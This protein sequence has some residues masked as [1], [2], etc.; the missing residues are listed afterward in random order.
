[1][2]IHGNTMKHKKPRT[3]KEKRRSMEF[4]QLLHLMADMYQEA[5]QENGHLKS[6]L[7]AHSLE[8]VASLK[9]D[10]EAMPTSSFSD[11]TGKSGK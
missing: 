7:A 3:T 8:V 11:P 10:P 9:G 6:A 4:D 2:T 5:M 1:M